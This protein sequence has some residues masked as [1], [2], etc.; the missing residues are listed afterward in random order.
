M[1]TLGPRV[2]AKRDTT[3]VREEKRDRPI[4]RVG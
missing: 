4:L 1:P 3:N 2:F